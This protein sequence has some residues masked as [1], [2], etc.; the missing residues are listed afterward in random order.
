MTNA[1]G[2]ERLPKLKQE[3]MTEDQRKVAEEMLAG[4]RKALGGP[5]HPWLRSPTMARRLAHF[6]EY[7]R[8]LSPLPRDLKELTV[9]I[10]ARHLGSRYEWQ[11]HHPWAVEAGVKPEVA[12]AISRNERP[13]GMTPAQTTIYNFVTQLERNYEVDDDTYAE[14]LALLGESLLIELV[15]YIGLYFT[16]GMTLSVARVAIPPGGAILPDLKSTAG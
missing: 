14:A 13:E 15:V 4:P 2:G 10:T 3:E 11:A 8:Y 1:S 5:F 12:D 6:G 7:M 16:V 9:L